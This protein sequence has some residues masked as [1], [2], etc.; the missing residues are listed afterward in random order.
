MELLELRAALKIAVLEFETALV[1][2]KPHSELLIM[3]KH[4]KELQYQIVQAEVNEQASFSHP[5]EF[6]WEAS[7]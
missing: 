3:Y 6:T 7:G 1:D 4:L 5:E 2:G